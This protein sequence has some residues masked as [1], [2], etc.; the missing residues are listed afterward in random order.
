MRRDYVEDN[1]DERLWRPGRGDLVR[2]RTWDIFDRYLPRSGWVVDVGGGPGTHAAHLASLG[3]EVLLV[4][5]LRKHVARARQR[6]HAQPGAPFL[7]AEADAVAV[8]ARNASAEAVLL[9]GPLHHLTGVHERL[10]V[11]AEARRVLRPGGVLLAEAIT[12]YAW[13]LDSSIH[14]WLHEA[15]A[16][17]VFDLNIATGLSHDGSHIRDRRF[18][19]YFH[20]PD[21][22]A[23][24][25]VEAG[26]DGIE[27]VAVEGF[28]WLL[29]DLEARMA[30][31]EPLLRAVRLTEREHSMLSASA[32]VVGIAVR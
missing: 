5:P 24:E 31:P 11:L 26:F 16:W 20:H 3:Y 4:D 29:G 7:V 15:G 10:A 17:D 30:D 1:E 21:D 13:L 32:H 28:A 19:G 18:S 2:L 22:L 8:P 14:G 27:L 6:A 9:M 25:L 12:R 23:T